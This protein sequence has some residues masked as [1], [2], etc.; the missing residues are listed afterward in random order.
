MILYIINN[1]S[2]GRVMSEHYIIIRMSKNL[3]LEDITLKTNYASSGGICYFN[4]RKTISS[5]IDEARNVVSNLTM[6]F[7]RDNIYK[8]Y[9][10][11]E[12]K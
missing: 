4:N 8:V 9:Q 7:G 2:K 6:T 12:V 11:V 10:L 1:I 5:S 3:T